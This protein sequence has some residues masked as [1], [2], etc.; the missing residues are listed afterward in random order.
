MSAHLI[1]VLCTGLFATSTSRAENPAGSMSCC[2]V[3]ADTHCESKSKVWVVVI[4]LSSIHCFQNTMMAVS[5]PHGNGAKLLLHSHQFSRELHKTHGNSALTSRCFVFQ[6]IH[7][8]LGQNSQLMARRRS[9]RLGK[10]DMSLG[11]WQ[12]EERK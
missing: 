3:L 2:A 1:I 8:R 12:V 10:G 7:Q 9:G 11:S 6:T 4:A 5:F